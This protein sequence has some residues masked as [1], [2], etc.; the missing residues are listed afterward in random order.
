M[1]WLDKYKNANGILEYSYV[2]ILA[3]VLKELIELQ[4]PPL[5]SR[6]EQILIVIEE[7]NERMQG[8]S[9]DECLQAL[10]EFYKNLRTLFQ[11]VE[12]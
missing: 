7:T 12:P 9:D 11:Y 2:L 1:K 5:T 6:D 4:T 8:A 3:D 10:Y